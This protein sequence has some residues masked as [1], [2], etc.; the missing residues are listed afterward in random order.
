[1]FD[2]TFKTLSSNRDLKKLVDFLMVQDLG[3]SRYPNYEDW[4]QRC[5]YELDIGYKTAVLAFSYGKLAG[6]LIYQPHNEMPSVR[7]LKNLRV[8]PNYR[9][10]N[11]ARFM[12]RQ[13]EVEDSRSFDLILCDVRASQRPLIYLLTSLGYRTIQTVS[14]YEPNTLDV[15]MVKNLKQAAYSGARIF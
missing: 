6:D 10:R 14:L 3:D 12:L 4:V 7:E 2:F 9:E 8:D 15:V 1:M 13:A 5:E 11:F